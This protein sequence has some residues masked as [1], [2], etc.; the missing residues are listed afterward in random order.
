MSL[1]QRE[2]DHAATAAEANA[3]RELAEARRRA[4]A[5]SAAPALGGGKDDGELNSR[6]RKRSRWDDPINAARSKFAAKAVVASSEGGEQDEY[7]GPAAPPN[8]FNISPGPRWD[9]VDRSNGF[10]S[11]LV[12]ASVVADAKKAARYRADMSGL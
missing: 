7:V 6:Q 3:Q 11:R 10:E 12:Q 8:R 5:I 4:D 9:G 1:A 2:A